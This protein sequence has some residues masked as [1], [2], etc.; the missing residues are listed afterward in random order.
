MTTSGDASI[1]KLEGEG[2]LDD[3]NDP[4]QI[5]ILLREVEARHAEQRQYADAFAR[6]LA[7]QTKY[8]MEDQEECMKSVWQMVEAHADDVRRTDADHRLEVAQLTA[9]N[10]FLREK[11][12]VL[13][14]TLPSLYQEIL[15]SQVKEAKAQNKR[16]K[17]MGGK[18][19]LLQNSGRQG[20]RGSSR[21]RNSPED[22]KKTQPQK[23]SSM[24]STVTSGGRKKGG[25]QIEASTVNLKPPP[26][27]Y[28]AEGSWQSIVCWVPAALKPPEPWQSI[29]PDVKEAIVQLANNP[30]GALDDKNKKQRPA[31]KQ[32]TSVPSI[33]VKSEHHLAPMGVVP[34]TVPSPSDQF[35]DAGS[36]DSE[37][38]KKLEYE[39]LPNWSELWDKVDEAKNVCACGQ[40]FPSPDAMFCKNCGAKRHMPSQAGRNMASTRGV[41]EIPEGLSVEDFKEERCCLVIHPQSRPRIAWDLFSMF[42]VFYDL[43]AIPLL[44]FEF[45]NLF[46]T[47][48][49]WVTRLFWT[50]DVGASILTGVMMRDGTV[51]YDMKFIFCRY[52]KTWMALDFII[53]STDWLELALIKL[54]IQVGVFGQLTRA[55]R[56]VRCVRLLRLLRMKEVMEVIHERIQSDKVMLIVKILRLIAF[57]AA[58]GHVGGCSFWGIGSLNEGNSWILE[59]RYMEMPPSNR[60]LASMHWSLTQLSGGGNPIRPMNS[61]ERIFANFFFVFGFL[62]GA[63]IV[64]SITSSITQSHIIKCN[65]SQSE[66][67]L[68]KYL[69]QNAI[70]SNLALRMQRSAQHAI[71]GDLAPEAVELLSV[72]AEPLRMEM[73][74]EMYNAVLSSHALFQKYSDN[75]H[76]GSRQ[77]CHR[78]MRALLVITGD[79]IFVEGESPIE[80]CTYFVLKGKLNYVQETIQPTDPTRL[81][82]RGAVIPVPPAS[83]EEGT[84]VGEKNWIAE[85]VLWTQ[86]VHQGTLTAS[87]DV[88]LACMSADK[89]FQIG[90]RYSSM[91]EDLKEYM[92]AYLKFM[93]DEFANGH[94]YTDLTKFNKKSK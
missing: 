43:I 73:H 55:T 87:S 68:R 27:P 19:T 47:T 30:S 15:V 6:M 64:S 77:L 69:K 86:W 4:M 13:T 49:D 72:V 71:S 81:N 5:S 25:A 26:G 12:S 67:A 65:Q 85:P 11:L 82:S 9:E 57:M 22:R 80:P 78:A 74:Y 42:L 59:G 24:T 89:F 83:A 34:G 56:A 79:E 10:A 32:H 58:F 60:Y 33:H 50:L 41:V 35:D 2:G 17:G 91:H 18:S 90:S 45:E 93:N 52:C 37:D 46:L 84:E 8:F 75:C 70:P 92:W 53:V 7:E 36:E 39:S 23:S 63:M 21:S 29:T 20:R 54:D 66:S 16:S 1:E 51:R 3:P 62:C 88:K 28:E 44:V 40:M 61:L 14:T 94:R 38:V 48:M 31:S 76:H